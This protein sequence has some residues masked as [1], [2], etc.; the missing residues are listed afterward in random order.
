MVLVYKHK[1]YKEGD[2]RIMLCEHKA[3]ILEGIVIENDECEGCS[4]YNVNCERYEIWE[5]I[6]K[7]S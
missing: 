2:K 6:C 3:F 5:E 1:E 7:T 4:G